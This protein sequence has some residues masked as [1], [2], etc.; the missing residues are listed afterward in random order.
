MRGSDSFS[1]TK[2]GKNDDRRV[3]DGVCKTAMHTFKFQSLIGVYLEILKKQ[4]QLD[5]LF[6]VEFYQS[7]ESRI[8]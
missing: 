7:Q 3:T 1:V 2:H 4:L 8:L 5:F 6:S